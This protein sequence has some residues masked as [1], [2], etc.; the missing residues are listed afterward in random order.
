MCT[1]ASVSFAPHFC[2]RAQLN[3]PSVSLEPLPMG[4]AHIPDL[5]LLR[6]PSEIMLKEQPFPWDISW[7]L[8]ILIVIQVLG[9]LLPNFILHG[10]SAL[11]SKSQLSPLQQSPCEKPPPGQK[12]PCLTPTCPSPLCLSPVTAPLESG[13]SSPFSTF[14]ADPE[15]SLL[16]CFSSTL[17][18]SS[19]L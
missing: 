5:L 15:E 4:D 10:F 8:P 18:L 17:A 12:N 6:L 14:A 11:L 16:S 9:N 19:S 3:L 13:F 1:G 2:L 7:V